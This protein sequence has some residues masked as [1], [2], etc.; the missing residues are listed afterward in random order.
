MP[1][2]EPRT[3]QTVTQALQNA[4]CDG[5]YLIYRIFGENTASIFRA[6]EDLKVETAGSSKDT[7]HICQT[8]QYHIH[9]T[10]VV[11]VVTAIK[12]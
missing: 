9:K 5:M 3:V 12:T 6:Q 2:F 10:Q 11:F 4:E 7:V 1:E 8:T